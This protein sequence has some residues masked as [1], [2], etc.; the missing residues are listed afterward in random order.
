MIYKSNSV[1]NE[2]TCIM[3]GIKDV[4]LNDVKFLEKYLLG[5]A[6]EE[7]FK[8]LDKISHKFKPH[9]FTAILLVQES[10]IAIHTYPEYNCLVFNIYSCRDWKDGRK[11]VEFFKKAVNPAKVSFRENRVEIN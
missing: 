3:Y 11:A 7:N 8:I 1:G 2:I 6:K 4:V 9:G 10:H 5:C